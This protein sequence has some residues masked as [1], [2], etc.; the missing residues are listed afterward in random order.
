MNPLFFLFTS[1]LSL[2][3][4]WTLLGEPSTIPGIGGIAY[5]TFAR[6]ARGWLLVRGCLVS[7]VIL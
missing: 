6:H 2:W 3:L 5:A 7:G 4:K 1:N